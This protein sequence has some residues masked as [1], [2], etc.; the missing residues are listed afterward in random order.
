MKRIFLLGY[1]VSHSISPAMQNAAL[2]DLGIDWQYELL[3]TPPNQLRDTVARLRDADCI[4]ANIT[5]PHKQAVMQFLDATSERARQIG[6][7]NTLVKRDGKLIG[8]NTDVYGVL[9][10]LVD[11]HVS[12]RGARVV[13]LGAGGAARGTVFALG[14]AGVASIAILNRTPAH[15]HTLADFTRE[16]FP[17]VAVTVNN[18][19]A[20]NDAELIINT[21]SVG[22]TPH[23]NASPMPEGISFPRRAIAFDLV[24]RPLQTRFLKDAERAG[25]KTISGLGMLVHQGALSLKLW[26][27]RDAPAQMMWNAASNALRTTECETRDA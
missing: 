13:V 18:I 8:D 11:E 23:T 10:T 27:G 21:T 1:P 14:E 15:A 4:G 6:A 20:L 26:T 25:A 24:Y 7:V 17:N 3:A 22:M 2:H 9:Q 12:V 5:I 16:Q 19:K